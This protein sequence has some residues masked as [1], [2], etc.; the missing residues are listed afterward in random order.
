ML[1][2]RPTFLA[3]LHVTLG[4]KER[5]RGGGKRRWEGGAKECQ[6]KYLSLEQFDEHSRRLYTCGCMAVETVTIIFWHQLV[7]ILTYVLGLL[8]SR[9]S[10]VDVEQLQLSWWSAFSWVFTIYYRQLYCTL[11]KRIMSSS[12]CSN[13]RQRQTGVLALRIRLT[14]TNV[15]TAHGKRQTI[16]SAVT[17]SNWCNNLCLFLLH[18]TV[19]Q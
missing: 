19:T 9:Q 8:V 7:N 12:L 13:L 5:E 11:A 16:Y 18:K 3:V 1:P 15:E 2:Y 14:T 6:W 4:G 17:R 10:S